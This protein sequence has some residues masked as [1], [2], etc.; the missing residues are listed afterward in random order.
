MTEKIIILADL[1]RVKAFRV[2]PDMMT[3]KP[4]LEL[5][6]DCEFPAAHQRMV[7]RVSDQAGSFTT[8]G[9]PGSSISEN[10]N[11]RGETE[12][13]LIQLIA[14]KIGELV[15]GQRCWYLAAGENINA[16]IVEQLSSEA[17]AALYK[18]IPAHWS[19]LPSRKCSIIS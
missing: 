8:G 5:V 18:N 2:T 11:L 7:D 19:R 17:K 6:Q 15:Q 13:R 10:H 1:G 9:R 4:Q 14:E 12:R 3:A 16:R